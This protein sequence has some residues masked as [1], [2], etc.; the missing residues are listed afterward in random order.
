M[1]IALIACSTYGYIKYDSWF[2]AVLLFLA[3]ILISYKFFVKKEYDEEIISDI[4]KFE[5]IKK[6]KDKK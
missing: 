5:V 4:D 2:L 1:G 6:R 3:G